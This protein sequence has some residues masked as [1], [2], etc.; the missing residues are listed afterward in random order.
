MTDTKKRTSVDKAAPVTVPGIQAMKG[1]R[2][3]CCITAYDYSSGIIADTAGM[4][5]ILVGD[6]LAMVVLGHEDTLSV[7]VDEMI[8]HI[9]AT[10][11]G[12]KRA[13]VVGDMPFMSYCTVDRALETGRRF[14]AEG[15]ARA[16]KLEGGAPV[17]PQIKALTEAGIPVMA[18]VGL[19]PQHIAKFGGFKAQGKSAEATK[20]LIKDAQAVEAAGAFCVVLEAIPVEAAELITEAVSI[21]TIGI[22]A[23]NVTDGQILVYHDTL[24][25]FD[26]F[27]PKFVRR[28]AELGEAAGSALTRYCEDVRRGTFPGDKNTLYMPDDQLTQLR[29]IKI[30]HKKK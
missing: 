13:L 14:I 18:H 11:R 25:L 17:A 5:L 6:S 10:S 23:G 16:V 19:T 20:T 22:G 1:T 3:I 27:T 7:T 12:A 21:P 9:R 15:H 26:R 28:F 2:K 4:D 30:K 24:G 29:K 8:H